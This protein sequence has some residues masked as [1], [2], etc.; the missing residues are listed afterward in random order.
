MIRGVESRNDFCVRMVPMVAMECIML[1]WTCV[2]VLLFFDNCPLAIHWGHILL[3]DT[4]EH[5]WVI[6]EGEQRWFI[7]V[8]SF[9]S[10]QIHVR[11]SH[12][13]KARIPDVVP[14][15]HIWVDSS[16]PNHH[17]HLQIRSRIR[18]HTVRFATSTTLWE[19]CGK[20]TQV[21]SL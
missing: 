14:K 16:S 7:V 12:I 9:K 20:L 21:V 19:D 2:C 18:Y 17:W 10:H 13:C 3:M 1:T 5:P 4:G 8:W 15:P 11:G 6:V